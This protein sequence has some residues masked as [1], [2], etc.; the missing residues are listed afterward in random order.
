MSTSLTPYKD[1][2]GRPPVE[3][4]GTNADTTSPSGGSGVCVIG[5][6]W[7]SGADAATVIA[8]EYGEL[9][10]VPFELD[11]ERWEV[12]AYAAPVGSAPPAP[13]AISC[14]ISVEATTFAANSFAPIDGSEHPSL[15]SESTHESTTLVGWLLTNA[16]DT[17]YR[18]TL[19]S[20]TGSP[21]KI[22]LG[23]RCFA[24]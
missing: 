22:V 8:G 2:T 17:M 10:R 16:A 14:V 4:A 7:G 13:L 1:V 19:V 23:I 21:A 6:E 20:F 12:L 11:F 18:F 24:P 5:A 3:L 15:S 9:P